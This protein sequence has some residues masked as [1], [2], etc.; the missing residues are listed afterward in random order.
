MHRVHLPIQLETG[1]RRALVSSA[2]GALL[3]LVLGVT[4]LNGTRSSAQA[5]ATTPHDYLYLTIVTGHM[6]K[7]PGWPA[8]EPAFFSVP[9]HALVTVQITNFDDGTAPTGAHSPFLT[10][11]GVL[12]NAMTVTAWGKHQSTQV[13]SLRS[14]QVSHTFTVPSLHLNVPV[15][16]RSTVTFTFRTGAAGNYTWYCMAPCGTGESGWGGAMTR[17]GYMRGTLTVAA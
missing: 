13:R 14:E 8:Y 5:T 15:P 11:S 16:A 17:L 2:L 6:L 1:I 12:G 7:Q 10:V 4:S 3:I 9:A